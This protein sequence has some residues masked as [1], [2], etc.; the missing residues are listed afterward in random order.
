VTQHVACCFWFLPNALAF[1][2]SCPVRLSHNVQRCACCRQMFDPHGLTPS[3]SH[4]AADLRWAW[5][6]SPAGRSRTRD[7]QPK[8]ATQLEEDLGDVVKLLSTATAQVQTQDPSFTQMLR[9]VHTEEDGSR[10][11]A[12]QAGVTAKCVS[13]ST[14]VNEN[15]VAAVPESSLYDEDAADNLHE[16]LLLHPQ[17]SQNP[18][19][20]PAGGASTHKPFCELPAESYPGFVAD[21]KALGVCNRYGFIS[22]PRPPVELPPRRRIKAINPADYPHLY[23]TH[24]V[25]LDDSTFNR[26]T[27]PQPVGIVVGVRT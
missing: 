18:M 15:D 6:A 24:D 4:E 21:A 23:G 8:Q 11:I 3:R 19:S 14:Q 7:A 22:L 17:T 12:I 27:C 1:V 26:I 5:S 20:G 25:A 9:Q 10:C 2:R 13:A 16:H